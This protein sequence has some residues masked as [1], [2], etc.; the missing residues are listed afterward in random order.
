MMLKGFEQSKIEHSESFKTGINSR[1]AKETE[2]Q[3][4]RKRNVWEKI[5]AVFDGGA[6]GEIG[7]DEGDGD[8]KLTHKEL[9]DL[10]KRITGGK[11]KFTEADIT[12]IINRLDE[13]GDGDIDFEEFFK[14]VTEITDNSDETPEEISNGIFDLVDQPDEDEEEEEEGEEKHEHQATCVDQILYC[15]KPEEEE[16]E[17]GPSISITELQKVLEKTGQELPADEVLE[18][19][20][21]IDVNGDG[22]V[23][24][25][26]NN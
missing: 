11:S 8:G 16:D 5:F 7:N 12:G 1:Q 22:Q 4:L 25:H 23:S 9:H 19:V 26:T 10:L 14:Y 6:D 15:C 24:F 20:S 2:T 17:E 13:N 18:I 3:K 21:D